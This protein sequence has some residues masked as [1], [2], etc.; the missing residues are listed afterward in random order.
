[1]YTPPLSPI[2]LSHLTSF[3]LPPTSN[4][5]TTLTSPLFSPHPHTL[6]LLASPL[7]GRLPFSRARQ[8]TYTPFRNPIGNAWQTRW[9]KLSLQYQGECVLEFDCNAEAAVFTSDGV[10]VQGLTGGKG[11]ERHVHYTMKGEKELYVEVACNGLFGLSDGY[12]A[13]NEN[14]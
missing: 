7:V 2:L 13:P 11:M 3:S 10:V 8:L 9:F 12:G 5:Y 14:R 1:M 4:T 6:N